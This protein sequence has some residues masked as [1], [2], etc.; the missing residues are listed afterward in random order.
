MNKSIDKYL[1]K[2]INEVKQGNL[3]E[4][5]NIYRSI[6]KSK[7]KH[8]EANHN[9]GVL[10]DQLGNTK[11]AISY[12]KLALK[13]SPEI[14]QFWISY[15]KSLIKTDKLDIAKIEINE[16]NLS[17]LKLHNKG[18]TQQALFE[19][20]NLF[21]QC[22]PDPGTQHTKGV[23]LHDLKKYEDAV[24]SFNEA[25]NLN[26]NYA[27]AHHNLGVS[28]QKLNRDEEAI[29]SFNKTINL[30]S[31]FFEVYNNL[32]NSLL[33]LNR[34]KE[35]VKNYIRAIELN[36]LNPLP[37]NNLAFV[38]GLLGKYKEAIKNSKKAI[39]LDS[40]F[41]QAH[42]NLGNMLYRTGEYDKA[43]KSYKKVLE[44]NPRLNDVYNNLAQCFKKKENYEKAIINFDLANNNT[45]KAKSLECLYRIKN[46]KEFNKRVHKYTK[47]D[48]TNIRIAA[49][50]AFVSNQLNQK[51]SYPFCRNPLDFI[52]TSN[53]KKHIP[54]L[55]IYIKELKK[56]VEN[57]EQ[58]WEPY[59]KS[60]KSGF[61][62]EGNIFKSGNKCKDLENI[63]YK[64]IGSYYSQFKSKKCDFINL[65]PQHFSLEGWFVKLLK[66]GHQTSHIHPDGWLS[67]VVYLQVIKSKK[68]SNEGALEL[69]LHGYDLPVLDSHYPKE[70]FKPEIGNIIL[71]PSSLFHKTIPFKKD[72]KRKVIAFDLIPSN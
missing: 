56:E 59:N 27:S 35:S 31:D 37:Y 22:P 42:F 40:N 23:I 62:T 69:G 1:K 26:P 33:K 32:G 13:S 63:I 44:L 21:E 61:Q 29:N 36:S 25:I 9:L 50:N 60:T 15:Y 30:K 11:E 12:F 20:E 5:E 34:H 17:L 64:E 57:V 16:K 70:I 7:P 24:N 19:I 14:N 28:L 8:P 55:N 48:K 45:S 66:N 71:F 54:N 52:Y 18:K 41:V 68:L 51:D 4:A 65:W 58:I 72:A 67:G 43:V 46:Y 47:S 10:I 38:Y 53:I 49:V 6:L 39:K 3:D 2:A